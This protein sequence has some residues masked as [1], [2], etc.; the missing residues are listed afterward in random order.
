MP[1]SFRI[2]IFTVISAAALA[3]CSGLSTLEREVI[4]RDAFRELDEARMEEIKGSSP[5]LKAHLLNGNVYV[6]REWGMGEEGK[7]LHGEGSL[8]SAG[9]DTIRKGEFGVGID[10]VKVFETNCVSDS[11]AVSFFAVM[12]GITAAIAAARL[13]E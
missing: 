10:S 3:G 12:S 1:K 2:F 13:A 6:I 8:L 9:R 11:S 7:I 5:I 4:P